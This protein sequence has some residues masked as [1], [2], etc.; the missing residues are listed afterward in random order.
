MSDLVISV[1]GEEFRAQE[2]RTAL[3]KMDKAHLVDLED[4]IVL[5]R[6]VSGAIKVHHI[7]HLTFSGAIGGG[8]LGSLFGVMFLNPV[9]AVV[10]AA[11]GAVMGAVSGSMS[12]AG[13]GQDFM[14]ELARHLKPGA[15]ALCVLVRENLDEVLTDISLFGGKVLQAS[16]KHEDEAQLLEVL[17]SIDPAALQQLLAR[18]QPPGKKM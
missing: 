8:F 9:F 15:S 5:R 10:G 6:T 13:I 2:V 16:L 7:T 1:F 12:H 11:A 4:A 14:E 18:K 3:M 17:D